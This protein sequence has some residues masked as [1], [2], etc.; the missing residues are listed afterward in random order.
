MAR[1]RARYDITINLPELL[2]GLID[3]PFTAEGNAENNEISIQFEELLDILLTLDPGRFM[4]NIAWNIEVTLPEIPTFP[5]EEGGGLPEIPPIVGG[6][7]PIPNGSYRVW[8][9]L[10]YELPD[11]GGIPLF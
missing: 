1:N 5:G 10:D 9:D 3:E 2:P 8:L 4:T 11:M 6:P 7:I